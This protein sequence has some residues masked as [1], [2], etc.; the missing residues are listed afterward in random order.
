MKDSRKGFSLIELMIVVSIIGIILT[1]A[2]PILLSS[3]QRAMDEK[4]RQ[5]VRHVLSAEQAYY[6]RFS[7]FTTLD[8]LANSDPPFL[9]SRFTSGVGLLDN[10]LEISIALAGANNEFQVVAF[11]PAGKRDFAADETMLI[12]EIE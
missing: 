1:T 8:T 12:W 2:I 3:R 11:N 4:A 9:D 5:S 10:G 7:R 6:T